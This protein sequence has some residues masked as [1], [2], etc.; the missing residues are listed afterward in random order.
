MYCDSSASRL[1]ILQPGQFEEPDSK[2]G[3]ASLTL[4]ACCL[5]VAYFKLGQYVNARRQLT[6]IL[7]V[8]L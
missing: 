5:A 7:E 2:L 4:V 3:D 6:R 8:R 1:Q